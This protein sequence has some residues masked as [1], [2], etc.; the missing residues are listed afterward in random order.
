[1]T[2]YSCVI[3]EVLSHKAL[4]VC[5]CSLV[6][7]WWVSVG[8]QNYTGTGADGTSEKNFKV[9]LQLWDTAGQER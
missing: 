6:T 1:M 7:L 5:V 8:L 4:K 3:L 9:H 2:I